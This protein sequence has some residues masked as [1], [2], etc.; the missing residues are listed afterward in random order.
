MSIDTPVLV[1]GLENTTRSWTKI[2]KSKRSKRTR[3][4]D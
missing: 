2:K 1:E 3:M 4:E